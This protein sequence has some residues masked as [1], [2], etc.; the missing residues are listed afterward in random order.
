MIALNKESLVK[1]SIGAL[2]RTWKVRKK[3]EG[4][5]SGTPKCV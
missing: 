3:G 2:G 4:G 5:D 1:S